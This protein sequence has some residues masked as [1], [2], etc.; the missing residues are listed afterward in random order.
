MTLKICELICIVLSA[1]VAGMFWG[2]WL[3]LSPSLATFEPGVFLQIV[4][5]MNRNMASLMTVLMPAALLSPVPVLFISHGERP[6]T[7]YLTLAGFALFI[8]A[9]VVTVFVEVPIVTQIAIWTAST[10][11]GNWQQ[12]R[13]RWGAFHVIRVAAG[14]AGV[15]LLVAG[16]IF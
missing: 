4:Q 9:I 12:L 8:V 10:L 14:L 7:F 5:R 1:L 15:A 6:E 3:A 2:P 16:A 11:P 13:D